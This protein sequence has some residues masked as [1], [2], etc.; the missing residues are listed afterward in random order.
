MHVDWGKVCRD[1]KSIVT[2]ESRVA[3]HREDSAFR[4]RYAD[5]VANESGQLVFKPAPNAS[6][7]L[8]CGNAPDGYVTTYAFQ[9]RD[10]IL[11]AN[12]NRLC[13]PHSQYQ[14]AVTPAPR[15]RVRRSGRNRA[16]RGSAV[17]AGQH[18][19]VLPRNKCPATVAPVGD[20][21]HAG[22]KYS[23]GRCCNT[24]R[25]ELAIRHFMGRID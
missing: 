1:V 7:Y 13:G 24:G 23:F 10:A 21:F 18:G 8:V 12:L 2:L 19:C 4:G 17:D 25:Q 6:S 5:V 11:T 14:A 16:P 3:N 22:S 15:G 9:N 20:V